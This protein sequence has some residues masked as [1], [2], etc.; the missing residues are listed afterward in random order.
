MEENSQEETA[1]QSLLRGK[2]V[3][4]TLLGYE[5]L[6]YRNMPG[7]YLFKI[8]ESAFTDAIPRSFSHKF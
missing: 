7:T 8:G 4:V 5:D 3:R 2:A 6:T 1:D